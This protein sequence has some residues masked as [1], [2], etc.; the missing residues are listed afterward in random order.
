MTRGTFTQGA[1]PRAFL[2]PFRWELNN[3]KDLTAP[4]HSSHS[5]ESAGAAWGDSKY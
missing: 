2:L 5:D 1:T 3:A 4:G